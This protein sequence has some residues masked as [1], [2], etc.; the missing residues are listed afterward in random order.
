[1]KQFTLWTQHKVC[2]SIS[3]Q[4]NHGGIHGKLPKN[5]DEEEN[6]EETERNEEDDEITEVSQDDEV[7]N[8][9]DH[10]CT[11]K[12]PDLSCRRDSPFSEV[13]WIKCKRIAKTLF[14]L[15]LTRF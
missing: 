3:L 14:L 8:I 12:E 7:T 9:T 15:M 13:A 11:F 5:T 10:N 6:E 4:H 2:I 1:M